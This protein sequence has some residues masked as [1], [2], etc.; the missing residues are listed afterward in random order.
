VEL[1]AEATSSVGVSRVEFYLN[2]TLIGTDSTAP[3]TTSWDTTTASNGTH[4]IKVVVYDTQNPSVT[5]E[6]TV[7]I[8]IN[9]P[10]PDTTPPTTP[11]NL[12]A[13]ASGHTKV[14]LSWGA[15]TDSGS[16]LKTYQVIRDGIVIAETT[17]TTYSDTTVVAGQTYQYTVYA[18]DKANNTSDASNTA[19]VTVPQPPD[20]TAPSAPTNFKTTSVS[21]T[22]V[23]LSWSAS[24]DNV[25]VAGYKLKRGTTELIKT[26]NLTF[27]DATVSPSTTY[28]YTL[29]AYD[30][31]GN[32]SSPAQLQVTT[33][34]PPATTPNT[35]TFNPIADAL[36]MQLRANKNY[37]SLSTLAVDQ[38]PGKNSLLKFKI[39]GLSGHE[40]T[41]VKLRLYTLNGTRDG[42]SVY[43]ISSNWD[44]KSVT[45][46]SAPNWA[47]GVEPVGTFNRVRN[48]NFTETELTNAITGD[49]TYSFRIDN[50]S[51]NGAT[52]ASKEHR[53]KAQIPI[54]FITVK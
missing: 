44:E 27:G 10:V 35:L 8:T 32:Y 41:S 53:K 12:T 45:W 15:S 18:V 30:A 42:G 43:P 9:N 17:N 51:W 34:A 4:T 19:D 2:S 33:S 5:A 26:Q 46:R 22:L 38:F 47:N 11:G 28:T 48:G 13:T 24:N 54:L 3:Y 20:T 39:Q 31:A 36:I 6:D 7:S 50:N 49:G 21:S 29:Q 16:G 40:V 14:D 37:G 25:G 23:T 52:Y 1:T